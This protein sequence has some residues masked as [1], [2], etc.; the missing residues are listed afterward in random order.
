MSERA[1]SPNQDSY[2]VSHAVS[3]ILGAGAI[4]LGAYGPAEANH[5]AR[6]T[7]P[8]PSAT[9]VQEAKETIMKNGIGFTPP[10]AA[11]A[12][13]FKLSLP[14][15]PRTDPVHYADLENAEIPHHF[16]DY[17]NES[18]A[19][20]AESGVVLRF[21]VPEDIKLYSGERV[22]R[23][24]DFD[25]LSS[26]WSARYLMEDVVDM[27]KEYFRWLG[28][29][30]VV[31][32]SGTMDATAYAITSGKHD[33]IHINFQQGVA[34]PGTL[35]HEAGHI[36][37]VIMCDSSTA[38]ANDPSIANLNQGV[39]YGLPA[40]ER[41]QYNQKEG[42][43]WGKEAG[44]ARKLLFTDPYA[45]ETVREDKAQILNYSQGHGPLGSKSFNSPVIIDKMAIEY[46]R[47]LEHAPQIARFFLARIYNQYNPS[48]P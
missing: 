21:G 22:P 14:Q 6:D 4:I 46:G 20:L 47:M 28:L 2:S 34:D 30:Q 39:S 48:M 42:W 27:P 37:D 43:S 35:K 15:T 38:A 40:S 25:N 24:G 9:L 18:K 45:D 32:T 19:M 13:R 26:L 10:A 41:E 3:S 31:V 11:I 23:P 17:F 1:T 12:A 5:I 29:K 8:V 36:A 44:A 16:M 7:C 33:T